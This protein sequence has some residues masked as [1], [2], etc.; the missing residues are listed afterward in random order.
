MHAHLDFG[1]FQQRSVSRVLKENDDCSRKRPIGIVSGMQV[2]LNMINQ[3]ATAHKLTFTITH[4][5]TS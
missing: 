5:S 3:V 2:M 4:C 1:L